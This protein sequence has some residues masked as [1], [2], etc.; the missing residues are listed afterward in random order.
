MTAFFTP[1]ELAQQLQLDDNNIND[2]TA[3]MLA[4]L[5]SDIIRDELRQQINQTINETITLYGDGSELIMLPER[6][7]TAVGTVLL[8]GQAVTPI[9]WRTN[10]AL[11]RVLYAGSQYANQQVWCWP[12]GVPVQVTY[13]HGYA[14]IPNTIKAVALE[15]AAAAYI[16]P[17]MA[18][19]QTAG[20]YSITTDTTLTLTDSQLTRLDRYRTIDI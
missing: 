16:N 5:T 6:P 4:D 11:W 7:V 20:P 13:T 12:K 19:S 15:L 8:N 1:I 14:V 10:G 17:S 18:T 2:A 9:D 3:S